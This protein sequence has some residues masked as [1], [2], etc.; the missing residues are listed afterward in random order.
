MRKETVRKRKVEKKT[1]PLEVVLGLFG[2]AVLAGA[3]A[4]LLL[5]DTQALRE[6]LKEVIPTSQPQQQVQTTPQRQ[7]VPEPQGKVEGK[8]VLCSNKP[9]PITVYD[10]DAEDGDVVLINGEKVTLTKA[11]TTLQVAGNVHVIGVY[12]GNPPI[13]FGMRSPYSAVK[14]E[15]KAGQEL[16]VPVEVKKC[17][18]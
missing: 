11:G 15:L 13:T 12:E 4:F 6:K 10:W 17:E 2:G 18:P 14:V 16:S 8:L 7:K 1:S 5:G 9:T 3:G